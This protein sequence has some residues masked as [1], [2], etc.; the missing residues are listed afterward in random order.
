MNIHQH[1]IKLMEHEA[2][3]LIDGFPLVFSLY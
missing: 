2:N 1:I 3:K